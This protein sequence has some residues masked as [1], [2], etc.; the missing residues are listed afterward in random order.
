MPSAVASNAVATLRG[1]LDVYSLMGI[2][3]K[4]TWDDITNK[5]YV[6][7]LSSAKWTEAR[8]VPGVGGRLG[9]SAMGVKGQL[10]VFGGY[11]IDGKGGQLT[12]P[13]VNAYVPDAHR[14]Y[15][16]DDI[17]VGV[18][19]A[20]IGVNHDRYVYLIGGRSQRG[21]VN[22][23]QVYD[24]E[25]NVW[26]QATPFPGAPV[27]GLAG[28]LGD[29]TIVIVNGAKK[30]P[31][32]GAPFVPSDECWIGRI[33]KKDPNK[34]E[35]SKLPAHPGSARFGIV[36]GAGEKDRRII[37]SGGTAKVHD[38]KG[39]DDDGKPAEFSPVTFDFDVHANRWET[40]SEDTYD[41]RSDTR[42]IV[43]TPI[44]MLIVGGL[45]KNTAVTARAVVVPK[46]AESSGND[47]KTPEKEKA[48]ETEPK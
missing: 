4:K 17:P 28:G 12:V 32:A 22:N 2:G 15:R 3:P 37:F 24:V 38:F 31:A 10:F 36:S 5:V 30:N 21:P 25:K 34:I 40:I 39:M 41:V 6:L 13:D 8:P 45:V 14:W 29:D 18:D 47:E 23:V 1:G 46:R 35:W 27:F 44:G 48:P 16:A 20:A 43:P 7:H 19:N 11:L 9:A 42:G 33:D 26:S